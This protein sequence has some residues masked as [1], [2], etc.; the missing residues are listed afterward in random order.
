MR[1]KIF[2]KAGFGV[3]L[4]VHEFVLLGHKYMGAVIKSARKNYRDPTRAR[5]SS[6]STMARTARI[7]RIHPMKCFNPEQPSAPDVT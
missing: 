2:F 7:A 5:V 6:D 4:N 1:L 3:L